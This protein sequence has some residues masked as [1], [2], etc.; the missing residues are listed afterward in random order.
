MGS[1]DVENIAITAFS[2]ERN[3]ERPAEVQAFATI[4]NF[5]TSSVSTTATLTMNGQ[6]L[7][8]EAVQIEAGEQTGLSFVI[9][10]EDAATLT[11]TLDHEDDLEI[12]NVAYT[13][14]EP[15]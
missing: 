9:E 7:D 15:T 8:A 11:L 10:T 14:P 4:E 13:G 1:S 12:D 3:A 6:F 5:G 2:T